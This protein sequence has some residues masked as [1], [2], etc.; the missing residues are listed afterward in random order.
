MARPSSY[1][2]EA[3]EEI[4]L[5]MI[6]GQ[7]LLKICSDP[8][9]PDRSTVYRWLKDNSEF[10]DRYARAREALM[11]FYAEQILT[12]AFDESGDVV[13]EQVGD[14]SKAVANHAKVQRDRLKIDTMKFLMAKLHPG[15]YGDKLPE[16]VE[17]RNIKISWES[18][19]KPINEIKLIGRPDGDRLDDLMRTI[20]GRTRGIE[21]EIIRPILDDDGNIVN[22]NDPG[23]LRRRILELEA[24][25]GIGNHEP[26][27]P[28]GP[29]QITYQPQPLPADL[30]PDEWELMLSV[31]NLVKCCMPDDADASPAEVFGVIERA[32]KEH[33]QPKFAD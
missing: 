8:G 29:P 11:D 10:R 33:L 31:L 2:I 30:A 13:I 1:N 16:T 25:L 20:D 15:R 27:T 26:R 21:R 12:I 19:D 9:M 14:K 17:D 18:E 3:V 23:A 6:N 24:K 28:S 7:G 4:C 32:L 5:R 22:A